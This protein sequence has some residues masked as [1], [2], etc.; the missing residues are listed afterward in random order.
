MVYR[1][2]A[3][4]TNFSGL[5]TSTTYG[6]FGQRKYGGMMNS[7][8]KYG[9]FGQHDLGGM[10]NSSRGAGTFTGSAGIAKS[11]VCVYSL[12]RPVFHLKR[13]LFG[14]DCGIKVQA[15]CADDARRGLGSGMHLADA[16]PA[17]TWRTQVRRSGWGERR[18]FRLWFS[19]VEPL[20]VCSTSLISKS[21]G[22]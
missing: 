5:S 1:F 21:R 10:M 15:V 22:V 2:Q 4:A 11:A 8:T 9:A 19:K 13:T 14:F 17:P 7:A 6:S 3:A 12:W 18:R 16:Y 20:A